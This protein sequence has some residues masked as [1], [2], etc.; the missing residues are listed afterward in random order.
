MEYENGSQTVL[1]VY[2]DI[3]LLN[4]QNFMIPDKLV[5]GKLPDKGDESSVEWVE[6]SVPL[7]L[8]EFEGSTYHYMELT[9][10]DAGE[11]ISKK[12]NFNF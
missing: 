11:N 7:V 5:I 8:P 2:E 9:A 6:I 10:P 1:D 12:L 4:R 3:I